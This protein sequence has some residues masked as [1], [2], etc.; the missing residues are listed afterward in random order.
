MRFG[1]LDRNSDGNLDLA[2]MQAGYGVRV[3]P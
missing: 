3:R 1:W 2:E